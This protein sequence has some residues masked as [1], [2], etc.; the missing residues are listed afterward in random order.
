MGRT[1]AAVM[2]LGLIAAGGWLLLGRGPSAPKA[3]PPAKGV[4]LRT[5]PAGAAP[6]AR[7]LTETAGGAVAPAEPPA[8]AA[9][10]A[11]VPEVIAAEIRSLVQSGKAREAVARADSLS[12]EARRSP[13]CAAA[14]RD[15]AL[16][17]A[18][19][20][21][22]EF[23]ERLDQAD[24]ARRLLGRLAVEDAVP[25]A[26]VRERLEALNRE[27][28]FSGRDVPGVCFRSAVKPGDTLDRLMRTEWKGRVRTGYGVVLWMNNV[29]SPDRL[30][31]GGIRVP[32][33]PVRLLVRKREHALWVLLGEVPVRFY[34]VGLGMNGRTPVGTFEIEEMIPRPDYWAPDGKRVPFGQKGNPLGT[35]WMG[36]K[37]TPDAQGFGVHGTDEPDSV[38]KDL[39]QGCV[40]LVNA[41]VEQ[42][43]TWVTVGTL[44]EI[45][46]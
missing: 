15:A 3:A 7:S 44:V 36:F 46:P 8:P 1:L 13:L 20:T 32:E 6:R 41:D 33:E 40:R 39:S 24:A 22:S 26:S 29:T 31:I 5:A 11:S 17:L 30:R 21:A 9:A 34:P 12:S 28:L 27:V 23:S 42:L 45:R 38:G 19:G 16:A 25:L 37:D 35:R 43:F 2:V 14:A 10:P 18:S 4:P